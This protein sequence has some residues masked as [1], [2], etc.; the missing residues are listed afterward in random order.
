MSNKKV[1]F[2]TPPPPPPSTT[3]TRLLQ[4]ADDL[5]AQSYLIFLY[6]DLRLLSATGRVRTK[7]EDLSIDS[8]N[9]VKNN[10]PNLAV[11]QSE[12]ANMHAR[13]TNSGISPAQIMA[14]LMVELRREVQAKR[15]R[16]RNN[17]NNEHNEQ[18]QGDNH[19]DSTTTNNT[20]SSYSILSTITDRKNRKVIEEDMDSL[21]KAYN[22][23]IGM[24]LKK[25]LPTVRRSVFGGNTEQS[26]TTQSPTTATRIQAAARM[27]MFANRMRGQQRRGGG[28]GGAP[29]DEED[30]D[31]NNNNKDATGDNTP[32]PP[33][34][35]TTDTSSPPPLPTRGQ[36]QRGTS[37][38]R[39]PVFLEDV[40]ETE[41]A[42]VGDA[43]FQAAA[44]STS[45]SG[46]VSEQE[47]LDLMEDAVKAR[48]YGRLDFM[49]DFFRP[50]SVSAVMIQS[51]TRIVWMNDWYPLKDL[52]YAVAVN[53]EK[54]EVLL[55]FR[56][57]ITKADWAHATNW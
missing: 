42:Q 43:F 18:Q 53:K 24:D 1:T 22:Y 26:S 33:P 31:N 20:S 9:V 35:T 44:S 28:D 14:A 2:Q 19:N 37:A 36:L 54:K 10:A 57:A 6:S 13:S 21:L 41:V 38:R 15:R 17:T 7:F 3:R 45:T 49:R 48:D 12:I 4:E 47:L 11:L 51:D 32:P 30:D 5:L 23:M 56:G 55:V 29:N 8:D 25:E 50:D 40:D 34:T 27:S 52:T 46:A 16:E 39:L